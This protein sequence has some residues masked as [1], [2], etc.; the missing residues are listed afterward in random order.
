MPTRGKALA[1]LKFK[2]CPMLTNPP[3]AT[4]ITFERIRQQARYQWRWLLSSFGVDERHLTRTHGPCPACGGKDRFRFDDKEGRGTFF[5]NTCGAGDGFRLL[6]LANGW[7]SKEALQAVAAALGGESLANRESGPAASQ[8]K[9]TGD[10]VNQESAKRKLAKI[11]DESRPLE[12]G[13]PG[14]IYLTQTRGI[15]LASIPQTVRIHG[16]LAYWEADKGGKP[17]NRGKHPALVFTVHSIEGNPVGLRFIYLTP[18]GHKL[19]NLEPKKLRVIEPGA[20]AGG[21]VRFGEPSDKLA[22]GEGIETSLAVHAATGLPVWAAGSAALLG[23]LA[24]PPT[25]RE[26]LIFG[27]SDANKVGNRA[28]LHLAQRLE[29][30]GVSVFSMCPFLP[31]LDW[32]DLVNGGALYGATPA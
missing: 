12:P 15:P 3:I 32:L 9:K 22:I 20:A 8:E 14:W 31:G 26:V 17:R 16:A 6:E 24:I 1:S 4:P 5:C 29:T 23:R 2:R 28:A 7:T 19:P 18:T 30:T 25:V 11:W 10:G 21:A 13:D 27:D